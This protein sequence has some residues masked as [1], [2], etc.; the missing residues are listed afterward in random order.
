MRLPDNLPHRLFDHFYLYELT[1]SQLAARHAIPNHPNAKQVAALRLLCRNVLEPVRRHF[2]IPIV[3]SSGFRC[4]PLNRLLGSSDS[5]SHCRGEAVDFEV[6]GVSNAA[7]AEW[8]ASNLEFDQL[9]V[10][11]PQAENGNAGWVHVS[12]KAGENRNQCLMRHAYGYVHGLPVFSKRSK[13]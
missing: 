7:L 3:P 1:R 9:I 8:I 11:Y 6:V 13:P 4:L 12:I 2:K 5:S 10:E